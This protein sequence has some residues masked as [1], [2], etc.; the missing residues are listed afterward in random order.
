M[1]FPIHQGTTILQRGMWSFSVIVF[2]PPGCHFYR[3]FQTLRL[4][5]QEELMLVGTPETRHDD[6]VRPA[7]FAIHAYFYALLDDGRF[8]ISGRI[9]T[10][11]ICI[12]DYGAASAFQR[13]V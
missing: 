10:S 5:V 12:E 13:H 6:I 2:H 9:L 1:V 7:A 4:S 3:L 8:P 11:L